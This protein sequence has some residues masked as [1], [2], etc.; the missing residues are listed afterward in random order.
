MALYQK[1]IQQQHDM[2]IANILYHETTTNKPE[3]FTYFKYDDYSP[4]NTLPIIVQRHDDFHFN[5]FKQFKVRP[6]KLSGLQ[7][8]MAEQLLQIQIFLNKPYSKLV[9]TTYSET[10][11]AQMWLDKDTPI[12]IETDKYHMGTKVDLITTNLTPG[13]HILNV[14]SMKHGIAICAIAVI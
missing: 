5:I 11:N 14:L 12:I 13:K 2:V 6:D 9:V 8:Y 7:T 4:N 10:G 3:C 1:E